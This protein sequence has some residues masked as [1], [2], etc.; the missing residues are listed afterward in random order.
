M[1]KNDVQYGTNED[2]LR[3]A[4]RYNSHNLDDDTE[5]KRYFNLPYEVRAAG[6]K[7]GRKVQEAWRWQMIGS[8]G[9]DAAEARLVAESYNN[10]NKSKLDTGTA[11]ALKGYDAINAEGH[12]KSDSYTVVLNRTKLILNEQRVPFKQEAK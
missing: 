10:W 3:F 7:Y 12:G 1:A 4:I 5:Q 11:M 8:L 6:A 9:M 2:D